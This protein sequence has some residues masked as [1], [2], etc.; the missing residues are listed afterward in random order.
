MPSSVAVERRA[1][2]LIQLEI[3][4]PLQPADRKDV[5]T[6]RDLITPANAKKQAGGRRG[7]GSNLYQNGLSNVEV[8]QLTA[9]CLP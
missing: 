1:S 3:C 6:P 9:S 8:H 7:S 4:V 5:Q 2:R